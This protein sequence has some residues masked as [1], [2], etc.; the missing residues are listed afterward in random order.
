MF[1]KTPSAKKNLKSFS[2]CYYKVNNS[3]SNLFLFSSFNC[4]EAEQPQGN[5]LN[6][7]SLTFWSSSIK[8]ACL[9]VF[10]NNACLPFRLHQ[11]SLPFYAGA[12][13]IDNLDFGALETQEKTKLTPWL[14]RQSRSVISGCLILSP[15]FLYLWNEQRAPTILYKV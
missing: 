10:I 9:F 5:Q 6:Q 13:Q 1:A 14:I 8:P 7:A 2:V 12:I 3:L 4:V 11:Q 15:C